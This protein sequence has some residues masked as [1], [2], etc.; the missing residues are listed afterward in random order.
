MM[1]TCQQVDLFSCLINYNGTWYSHIVPEMVILRPQEIWFICLA[2]MSAMSL[3]TK[4]TMACWKSFLLL[5]AIAREKM[6]SVSMST[7]SKHHAGKQS[8]V[9]KSTRLI[10]IIKVEQVAGK[11]NFLFSSSLQQLLD[12]PFPN[13]TCKIKSSTCKNPPKATKRS[14]AVENNWKLSRQSSGCCVRSCQTWR[15][16]SKAENAKLMTKL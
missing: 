3:Q 14:F 16:K 8:S 11:I 10:R 2:F 9:C 1:C 7:T 15:L 12:F 13:S 4:R 6:T 5:C